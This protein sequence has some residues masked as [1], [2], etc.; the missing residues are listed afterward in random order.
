MHWAHSRGYRTV[1][2]V[3]SFVPLI[4]VGGVAVWAQRN[5][6]V[7]R[8]LS[9]DYQMLLH[10]PRDTVIRFCVA[11]GLA[12]VMQMGMATIVM[13]HMEKRDDMTTG[14]KAMWIV[15]CLF[16]GSIFLPLF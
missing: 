9:F 14:T 1:F 8:L 10:G 11:F 7:D 15:L 13:L 16:V 5:P 4:V 3:V 12:I 2:G 6:V